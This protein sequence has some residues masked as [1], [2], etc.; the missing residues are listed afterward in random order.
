MTHIKETA[1]KTVIVERKRLQDTLRTNRETHKTEFK[2]S[3]EGFESARL[4]LIYKVKEQAGLASER[5]NKAN[6]QKVHEAYNEFS[7]LEKPQDHSDDYTQ[8]IALME[9]ETREQVELSVEDFER[10][11]RDNWS[12]QRGFKASLRAYT[13]P[14]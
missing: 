7:R 4:D 2:E 14:G 1:V 6:R 8:A 13:S 10:F 11:V 12:W 3:M 5:N 9:W